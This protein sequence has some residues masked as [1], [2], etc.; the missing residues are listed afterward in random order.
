[1]NLIVSPIR[2]ILTSNHISSLI[3]IHCVGPPLDNFNPKLFVESWIG[4]RKRSASESICLKRN[5]KDLNKES[6]SYYPI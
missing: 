3:F 5:K 4:K 6:H 1:M 2:N